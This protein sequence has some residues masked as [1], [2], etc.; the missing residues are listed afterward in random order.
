MNQR[1]EAQSGLPGCLPLGKARIGPPGG[2]GSRN[3]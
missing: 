2:D 3:G 1:P